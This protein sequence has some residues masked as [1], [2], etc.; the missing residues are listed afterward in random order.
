MY[1]VP[2]VAAARA[3]RDA[4][5]KN[6]TQVLTTE[7]SAVEASHGRDALCK[8]LYHRLFTWLTSGINERIKVSY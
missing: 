3:I 6:D 5:I 4:G 1:E 8:A 7:M 2:D